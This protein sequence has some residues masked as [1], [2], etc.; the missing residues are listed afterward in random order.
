MRALTSGQGLALRK[1]S[2][3]YSP[4]PLAL[5]GGKKATETNL[6]RAID[7]TSSPSHLHM[8]EEWL[9]PQ[10]WK[11]Q[12]QRR[13]CCY[14]IL[15]RTLGRDTLYIDLFYFLNAVSRALNLTIL[16]AWI[17]DRWF[18]STSVSPSQR[19]LLGPRPCPVTLSHLLTTIHA[20]PVTEPPPTLLM[21][22]PGSSCPLSVLSSPSVK[23][24]LAAAT[25]STSE[26]RP[27]INILC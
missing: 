19:S 10:D 27:F 16:S 17:F 7:I 20:V 25:P 6:R 1:G 21:C 11:P 26:E 2:T 22:S 3:F 13:G 8:E 12:G 5:L 23:L 18:L 15:S 14:H 9:N 24:F 4:D